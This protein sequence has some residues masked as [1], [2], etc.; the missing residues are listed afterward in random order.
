MRKLTVNNITFN[1]VHHGSDILN[2]AENLGI[3]HM[4][5]DRRMLKRFIKACDLDKLIPHYD[6]YETA[7]ALG[8]STHDCWN[9]DT[10]IVLMHWLFE[11]KRRYTL[12]YY[13]LDPYW[14]YH[15]AR[16]AVKDVYGF[17]VYGINSYVEYSRLIDGAEFAQHNGVYMSTDTL[18]KLNKAWYGRWRFLEGSRMQKFEYQDFK[19]YMELEDFEFAEMTIETSD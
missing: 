16:H 18:V 11:K 1:Y 4:L 17:E 3:G 10:Q 13:G 9:S 5:I 15:D 7:D 2:D 6:Q 8:A 14:V 12:D 19:P